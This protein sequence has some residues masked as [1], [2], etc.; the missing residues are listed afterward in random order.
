MYIYIKCIIFL[1]QIYLLFIIA[2]V[3]S[4]LVCS[5]TRIFEI[6]VYTYIYIRIYIY[7][8]IYTYIYIFLFQVDRHSVNV[9]NVSMCT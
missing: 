1:D 5:M 8:Y 2:S 6:R 4:F 3:A 9:L 7:V